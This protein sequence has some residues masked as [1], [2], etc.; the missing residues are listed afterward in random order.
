M[1]NSIASTSRAD[2]GRD[3]NVHI[4]AGGVSAWRRR[5]RPWQDRELELALVD[6][7][8]VADV[9]ALAPSC[10]FVGDTEILVARYDGLPF[11]AVAFH[12]TQNGQSGIRHSAA[13]NAD[14][15]TCRRR[16]SL[17]SRG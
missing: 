7:T 11:P 2:L 1:L 5:S 3:A 13:Q 15:T 4:D 9:T 14:P 17:M 6:F 10:R 16:A 8:S 12:T